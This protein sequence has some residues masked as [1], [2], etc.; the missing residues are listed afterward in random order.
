MNSGIGRASLATLVVATTFLYLPIVVLA[1]FSFN[2]SDLMA[3]PL[4]GF[5][6]KWYGELAGN[7]AF[8]AG[9]VT[10]TLVAQPVGLIGMAVG[11]AAA[12]ALT[13]PGLKWRL[14][15]AA[16][17]LLPF[18]V[19]KSVLSIAQA[20]V[21]SRV[22]LERGAVALV[23]AQALVV[24][25][26]TTVMIASVLVRIDPRLDE[27]ARDL[28]ATPWQSFRLVMLPQ[29]KGAL[30]GA[31]SVGVILS[32]A[33]LTIAMFLAGRT[34]PLSLMVASEFRRELRPD[35]NAMQVAVLALTVAIV[36]ASELYRR[37]RGRRR[38][39]PAARAAT[40]PMEAAP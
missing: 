35:L 16:L 39:A 15:F 17:V 8:H 27:A 38:A 9:F 32:L 19:P 23:L 20:M 2:D 36:A 18:L 13:A 31:Y 25:P 33:D 40:A 1:V 24:V 10:S 26:F 7:D 12:L 21:M 22:G 11:L 14:G 6:L 4:S 30:A 29:L 37:R 5:T 34:Q 28:G 3:F